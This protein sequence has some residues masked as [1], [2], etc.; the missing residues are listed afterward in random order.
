MFNTFSYLLT[1]E[2]NVS[3]L[4]A[5]IFGIQTLSGFLLCMPINQTDLHQTHTQFE[6][7]CGQ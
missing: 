3:L 5:A 2:A 1:E 7:S 6:A 4:E